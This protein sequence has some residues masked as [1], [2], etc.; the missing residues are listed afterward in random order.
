M[1]DIFD[2]N[3]ITDSTH[4]SQH[5]YPLLPVAS[6]GWTMILKVFAIISTYFYNEL[7]H[8]F[9]NNLEFSVSLLLTSKLKTETEPPTFIVT[10]RC[11]VFINENQCGLA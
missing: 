11:S 7:E 10:L 2:V 4:G 8:T 9:M 6:M 5:D 1:N 3:S